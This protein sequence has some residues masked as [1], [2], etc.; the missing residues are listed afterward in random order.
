[1]PGVKYAAK[2][3]VAPSNFVVPLLPENTELKSTSN[4]TGITI[5]NTTARALRIPPRRL[6]A[7]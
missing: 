3:I 1:M 2:S 7:V 4:T 6:N 5:V